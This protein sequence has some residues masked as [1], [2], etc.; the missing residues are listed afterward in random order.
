MKY[1]S[2]V[3]VRHKFGTIFLEI[4]VFFARS[5]RVKIWWW[6]DEFLACCFNFNKHIFHCVCRMEM[7]IV[8]WF[9]TE[10]GTLYQQRLLLSKHSLGELLNLILQWSWGSNISDV[11]WTDHETNSYCIK[12]WKRSLLDDLIISFRLRYN[13][14]TTLQI[15]RQVGRKLSWENWVQLVNL[16]GFTDKQ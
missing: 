10:E 2:C 12:I 14:V 15:P 3:A 5:Y 1:C 11:F 8:K 4:T 13:F 7:I 9:R 16:N 6:M